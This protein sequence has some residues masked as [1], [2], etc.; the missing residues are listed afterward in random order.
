[1]V[2]VIKKIS[3]RDESY[4]DDWAWEVFKALEKTV[5]QINSIR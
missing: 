3:D 1:M 2:E 4:P 5:A